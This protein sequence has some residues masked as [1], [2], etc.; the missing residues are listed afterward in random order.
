MT[1]SL[2]FGLAYSSAAT[3]DK[4]MREAA[5][6]LAR[7]P[8]S[9]VCG[10]G[11][12]NARNLAVYGNLS[13]TGPALISGWTVGNVQL[14]LPSDNCVSTPTVVKLTAT[15][16]YNAMMLSVFILS[17]SLSMSVQHEETWIGE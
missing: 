1:H 17:N 15:P 12:T 14:A 11:L 8:A 2:D 5:R 7:V 10:W 4:S 16:Q 9:A 3:A 6:Y 13:G